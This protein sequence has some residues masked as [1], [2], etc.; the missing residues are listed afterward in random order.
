ML[1]C[2]TP[3][4]IDTS[5]TLPLREREVLLSSSPLARRPP[6]RTT[7][8]G[9]LSRSVFLMRGGSRLPDGTGKSHE[10]KDGESRVQDIQRGIFVSIQ[11][12]STGRTDVSSDTERLLD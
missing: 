7:G 9:G 8:R 12:Q 6:R 5:D 2:W 3:F 4:A 11:D 10:K 1:A